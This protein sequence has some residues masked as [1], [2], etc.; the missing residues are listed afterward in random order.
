MPRD[1]SR[2]TNSQGRQKSCLEC[3]K[4]KR[5]CDLRVPT[6]LRCSKQSLT[7]SYPPPPPSNDT[8]IWETPGTIVNDELFQFNMQALPSSHEV[9]HLDFDFAAGGDAADALNDLLNTENDEEVQVARGNYVQGKYF[10]ASHISDMAYCRIVYSIEQLK[11]G[12]T[13]MV[14]ENQTPWSHPLLYHE[15]M[16]R[17]LQDAHAACALYVSRNDMNKVLVARHIIDRATELLEAPVPTQTFEFLAYAQCLLLYQIVHI[18]SADIHYHGRADATHPHL[19]AAAKRLQQYLRQESDPSGSIPLFPSDSARA[20]WKAFIFRE[21]MRR[22]MVVLIHFIAVCNLIRGFTSPCSHEDAAGSRLTFS[23][24]LWKATNAIDFALAWNERNHLLVS[25][26]DLAGV[27]ET[28]APDD[29]DVFGRM[30][31]TGIIGIDDV[32]GWFY[33]RGGTF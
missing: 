1:R 14:L 5:R 32:K 25:D 27:L 20:A 7:C 22:T 8:P 24:H 17:C 4:S 2:T 18:F 6:C 26:M 21:S 9:G 11:L 10:S 30:I 31:M 28:A 29:I 19:E 3:A 15:Y 33:T 13:S 12:P 23:A 16:P